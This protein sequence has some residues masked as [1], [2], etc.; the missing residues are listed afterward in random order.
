M[1][2]A[3]IEGFGATLANAD[4]GRYQR[5]LA[6]V[7]MLAALGGA[8]PQLTVHTRA[9]LRNGVTATELRALAEHVA[10]YAGF[11]R[12]LNAL[13]VFDEVIR[14]SGLPAAVPVRQVAGTAV[15]ETGDAGPVVV[16]IHPLG[17]DHRAWAPVVPKLATGRRVVSYDLRGHGGAAGADPYSMADVAADVVGLL[18]AL[19]VDQAHLAGLSFGGAIAQAAAVAAPERVASLALLGTTDEPMPEVFEAR[20]V[21]AER[22][23]L[24]AQVAPSLTRWFTPDALARNDEGVRY[25][26]ERVLRDDPA[27]W[28]AAWRAFVGLDV[29]GRLAAYDRPVMVVAGEADVSCPPEFARGIAERIPGA[30]FAVVPSAPHMMSLEQP[31]AVA[32]V[33]DAFL[34][35]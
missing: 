25:A 26:R 15:A 9:A 7:A 6:T 14:E 27:D 17:L 11:P 19:G 33:L 34:P 10:M 20:A 5:E 35:R 4:L 32:D 24:A 3:V 16:L 13:G 22:D 31:D 21:A 2:E 29:R 30:E 23:G 18:D 1:F 28:A 12:G 8:E